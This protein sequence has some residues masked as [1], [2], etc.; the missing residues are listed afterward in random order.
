MVIVIF[1]SR[2]IGSFWKTAQEDEGQSLV[3]YTLI[4]MLISL[5][6]IAPLTQIGV[7]VWN[8]LEPVGNAL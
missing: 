6:A 4:L 7:W 2:D 3:E 1:L 5:L 8:W